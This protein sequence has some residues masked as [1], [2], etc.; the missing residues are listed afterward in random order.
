[1]TLMMGTKSGCSYLLSSNTSPT[2]QN[3][4]NAFSAAELSQC[5]SELLSRAIELDARKSDLVEAQESCRSRRVLYSEQL[6]NAMKMGEVP[7]SI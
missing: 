4:L 3:A 1:M 2:D 6:V 7:T 5:R